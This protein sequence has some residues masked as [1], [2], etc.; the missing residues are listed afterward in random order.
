MIKK[1]LWSLFAA[2]LL[3]IVFNWDLAT[4][5]FQQAKGQLQIVWNTQEIEEVLAD[6]ATSDSIKRKIRIV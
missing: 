2:I 3:L 5:G 4:Y 6:S 1:V